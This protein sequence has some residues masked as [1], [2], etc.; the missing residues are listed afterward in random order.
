MAAKR[1][2]VPA[3]KSAGLQPLKPVT[4]AFTLSLGD[5]ASMAE[6]ARKGSWPIFKVKLGGEGDPARLHAVREAAPQA[7]LVVDA[8]EAWNAE[9]FAQNMKACAEVGVELVEQPLPADS[10]ALLKRCRAE[11]PGLRRRER[12]RGGRPRRARGQV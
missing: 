5:P 6:A 4:T 1:D 7:R 8:N 10:D 3:W 11:R 9:N 12:A 2:G